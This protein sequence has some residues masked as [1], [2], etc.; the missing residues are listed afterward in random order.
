VWTLTTVN[1]DDYLRVSSHATGDINGSTCETMPESHF[2]PP[3]DPSEPSD[4]QR[5]KYIPG[6]VLRDHRPAVDSLEESLEFE[7]PEDL[8]LPHEVTEL[9]TNR[10]C[11]V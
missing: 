3:E 1:S 8:V 2:Q 11:F 6:I 7:L 10:G 5:D 4:Y 9:A